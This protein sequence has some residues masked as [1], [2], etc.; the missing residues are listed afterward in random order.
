M[1]FSKNEKR[2]RE[3]S[4]CIAVKQ[5]TEQRD[6]GGNSGKYQRA[7][8]VVAGKEVFVPVQ[9]IPSFR[10]FL[11]WKAELEKFGG[12]SSNDPKAGR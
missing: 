2:N 1:L 8:A 5:R 9:R 6:L 10:F 11:P 7:R 4:Q 12:V 3:F